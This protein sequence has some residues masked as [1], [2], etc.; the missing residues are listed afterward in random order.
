VEGFYGR[1]WSWELRRD[2]AGFLHALGLNTYL[3]CPKSDP[4]LRKRWRENWPESTRRS[5]IQLG[6]VYRQCDLL[7]GVG[8]SPFALYLDYSRTQRAR[9]K[10]RIGE[11]N[12]LGGS[13]LAVLF[14]D[15]P[16]DC[17][18]LA[19]RQGEIVADIRAWSGRSAAGLPDLL[20]LRSRAR[21][22][23]RANA[24]PLLGNAWRR[25]GP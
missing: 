12:D 17:P 16:G 24:G 3:Y 23:F 19:V 8:L 13:L 6:E 11:I 15:M 14:D 2:Y 9:L 5:L 18:D 4:F 22:L 7:W 25:A 21:A 1:E 10:A 20:Q